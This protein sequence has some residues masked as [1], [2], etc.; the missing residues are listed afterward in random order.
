M[1]N[2]PESQRYESTRHAWE[3]IWDSA[4]VER[5]LE[6]VR[7]SR[8]QQTFA[9]FTPYLPRNALILEAGSG[10]SAAV[11]TLRQQGYHIIGMDYAVNALRISHQYDST[12]PLLA[13]DV[14]ALPFA[15]NSLGAYLS[16]GVLEH[17]EHG[18][19]P[20]MAEAYR[21]L[22]PGGILV[23]TIPYPNVVH[24]FVE[25][26]RA[27]RREN[28]LNDDAFYESTY[29][30]QQLCTEAERAGFA[31]IKAV[32]TTHS[33]TL[34]G[35]GGPFRAPGYYRTSLLAEALGHILRVILPWPFNFSTLLIGRK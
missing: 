10:L 27:R 28:R 35:L 22:Q 15:E 18:M 25:W 7:S 31:V 26:R 17:F 3:A 1:N 6:T 9:A 30:R 33:Y 19:G 5:E 13:G 23:L 14:H 11:I 4:S 8:A 32:P 16:F 29:N 21:V 24:Q 20:A 2:L 34:W 12:L